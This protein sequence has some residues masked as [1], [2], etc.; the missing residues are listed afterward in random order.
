MCLLH[1][2]KNTTALL[3]LQGFNHI[4]FCVG[5]PLGTTPGG[6]IYIDYSSSGVVHFRRTVKSFNFECGLPY[7]SFL[8]F[9]FNNSSLSFFSF[10]V[11]ICFSS[12]HPTP[13]FEINKIL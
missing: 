3:T 9:F 11:N 7:L 2:Q 5:D 13:F 8:E 10:L 12:P 1:Y 6:T 4:V